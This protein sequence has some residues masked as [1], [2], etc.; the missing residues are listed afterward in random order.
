M[1]SEKKKQK[2]GLKNSNRKE[3]KKEYQ[4]LLQIH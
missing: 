1:E 3:G 2:V 4:V